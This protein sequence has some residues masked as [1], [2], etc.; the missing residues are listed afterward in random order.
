[1]SQSGGTGTGATDEADYIVV[2]AGSAGCVLANRLTE[3]GR[4]RV[5]LLE[6]GPS[7]RNPWIHVPLGYG[8]LFSN[9]RVNWLYSSVPQAELNDRVI[10]QPRG[11]VL[12]GSSSI[13]GLVYIRGQHEDFDGWRQAGNAGWSFADVLPYFRRSEDQTR[14]ADEYHGTGGPLA[15]SDATEP[16]PLCD[17]FIEACAEAGLPRNEDFN[18]ASQ[19]GGGY[20]Q[21]TSRRGRRW[22]TAVGYLRP[23]RKRPNL[24]IETEALTTRILFESRR[25]VGVEYRQGGVTRAVR[26][27]REV[28]LSGGAINSPQIMQLSGI[29]PGALLAQHGIP[30]LHDLPGVGESF[31]DHFQMRLVLRCTQPITMNDELRTL[32]GRARVGLRYVLR[33]KGPLTVSAGYAAAFFRTEPRLATPDIQVH[34]LTLSTNRM[35]ERLHDFSGFTASVCQLRPE[36]RG[37]V[38]ITSPDPTAAPAIDPRYVAERLDRDT[39]V[40]AFHQLRAIMK[41]PAMQPFVDGEYLPGTGVASDDEI[42]AYGRATGTTLYH[43]SCSCRMGQDAGAVVDERLRVRGIEGLRVVDGSIMPSV[44]SGNTNAAIVMIGEK[45]SDM[46]REDAR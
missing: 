30:V 16:H 32:F 40:A 7:D 11:K 42:L 43:P 24:K 22:S 20:F 46:I 29:G 4:D 28:I 44:V 2:G 26:A 12:G 19:E 1:M 9:A 38:R 8:K 13:N 37:S 14:G 23:A 33:R 35:G 21:T 36:S 3:S 34:F 39:N 41:Q 31:Q 27:R 10:Y 45:A 25:A 18:G 6:A 17:A 15:V 5:L